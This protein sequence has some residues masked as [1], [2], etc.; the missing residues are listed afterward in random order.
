VQAVLQSG[1]VAEGPAVEALE[2]Q[3]CTLNG[4]GEATA[5]SSG[6]A[7]LF[8]ALHGLGVGAGQ[9]VAVPTYACSALLNAVKMAGAEPVPVDVRLDD[10]T[11]DADALDNANA[12]AAIAVHTFGA[13]ANIA[14]LQA[15]TPVVVEDCCQSLG[16]PQ[17]KL[18]A[19][20]IYSFYATKIITG[21][22]GGLI[23]DASGVVA[24]RARDY[25]EFDCR[26]TYEPRF[27]FQLTDIQAAMV[28][29]QFARLSAIRDRRRAIYTRYADA[30]STLLAAG[31]GLQAGVN[32]PGHLPYRCVLVAPDEA[33]RGALKTTMTNA[34]VRT[35]VPVER[36]ELLHNYLGLS[37][38]RFPNG[39]RLARTT[40]SVPLYPG[41]TDDEVD[42]VCNKV[43]N[44]LSF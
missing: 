25:R 12:D 1:W 29:S 21:G 32:A 24:E 35:I 26:E 2:A 8:L 39:E 13:S 22:Q 40:L 20:A 42:R 15:H 4:G 18:G 14:A 3:F 31:W 11:L 19:A 28:S 34:E 9:K 5:V 41:L 27:N 6:T 43:E 30:A 33:A 17:G 10:F 16:G 37:P 38:D 44:A 7:A 23:W 36:Y